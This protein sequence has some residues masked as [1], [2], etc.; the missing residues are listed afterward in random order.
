MFKSC[1]SCKKILLFKKKKF[2]DKFYC[3][4]CLV[5]AIQ[6]KQAEEDRLKLEKEKKTIERNKL[7]DKNLKEELRIEAEKQKKTKK[8]KLKK[9]D[10]PIIVRPKVKPLPKIYFTENEINENELL[11]YVEID[12]KRVY[13]LEWLNSKKRV[14][15]NKKREIRRTH[16][17]G[18]S[19]EK[20]QKFVDA[21]KKKTFEWVLDLLERPG[22]LRERYDK[23]KVVSNDEEL[24]SGVEG[25]LSRRCQ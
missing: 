16:A 2:E 23:T 18:F 12:V 10:K 24:R 3:E 9:P 6:Q 7:A 14:V 5:L 19:A 21:K 1:Y 13:V 8:K 17:G 20:F 15:L 25:F 11:L 4:K 22:V